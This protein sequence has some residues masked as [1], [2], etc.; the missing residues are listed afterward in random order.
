MGIINMKVFLL[1]LALLQISEATVIH[2]T[3][4]HVKKVARHKL[5]PGEAVHK[6]V[7]HKRTYDTT[8]YR[9]GSRISRPTGH[10]KTVF[11]D[12]TKYWLSYP[13]GTIR[14]EKAYLKGQTGTLATHCTRTYRNLAGQL[15]TVWETY[16]Q[17]LSRCYLGV[18]YPLKGTF[19]N[20]GW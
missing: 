1:L 16:K 14:F 2:R 12:Q 9:F 13:F 7:V 10:W 3:V 17:G 4:V 15:K 18:R 11:A 6:S 8:Y 5:F 20:Q 19:Y